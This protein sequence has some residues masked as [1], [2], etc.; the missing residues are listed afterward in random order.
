MPIVLL[1]ILSLLAL[2]NGDSSGVLMI[3]KFIGYVAIFCLVGYCILNP[4]LLII[5]IGILILA[6]IALFYS[7]SKNSSR[8]SK[9]DTN[10]CHYANT[11]TNTPV[12]IENK[13]LTDFQAELQKNTK[14][15]LQAHEERRAREK[16]QITKNVKTEYEDIKRNLLEKAQKGQYTQDAY[17]KRIVIDYASG[18]QKYVSNKRDPAS[19]TTVVNGKRIYSGNHKYTFSA[20]DIVLYDF[21]IS[22]I[23]KFAKTD[24]ITISLVLIDRLTHKEYFSLPVSIRYPGMM[25]YNVEVF[26]RCSITY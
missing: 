4:V 1:I 10:A 20:S 9:Q 11:T 19:E 13:E 24:G 6:L 3:A 14:T 7:D 8:A 5:V 22:E 21:Y 26:L 18:I 23:R 16:E 2:S 15:P 12:T 25:S 17:G